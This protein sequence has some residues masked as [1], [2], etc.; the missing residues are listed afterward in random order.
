MNPSIRFAW[1]IARQP[2]NISREVSNETDPRQGGG[3]RYSPRHCG[4]LLSIPSSRSSSGVDDGNLRHHDQR[5]EATSRLVER[6]VGDRHRHGSHRC[7]LEPCLSLAPGT[8]RGVLAVQRPA[9][10]ER[11]RSKDRPQRR[12]VAGRRG[13]AWHG[14]TFVHSADRDS[15]VARVDSLPQDPSRCATSR[16]SVWRR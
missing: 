1:S 16:S 7:I 13:L 5:T 2:S 11:S 10:E 15:P 6:G 3:S 4:G 8:F 14:A 12:R 9:R